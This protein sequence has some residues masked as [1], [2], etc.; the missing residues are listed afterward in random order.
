MRVL[1]TSLGG[2][3]GVVEAEEDR[4]SAAEGQQAI[5]TEGGQNTWE[6]AFG[7]RQIASAVEALSGKERAQ[8]EFQQN[9][10]V[11]LHSIPGGYRQRYSFD[12]SK[13]DFFGHCD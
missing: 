2:E 12:Q 13:D 11:G 9:K 4:V 3:E 6:T 7:Q 10:N 5:L 1:A 8:F